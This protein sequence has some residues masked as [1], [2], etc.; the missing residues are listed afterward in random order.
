MPFGP[1]PPNVATAL[2][3]DR[4]WMLSPERLGE[5]FSAGRLGMAFGAFG[6]MV[7][8][9]FILDWMPRLMVDAEYTDAGAAT[10]V[11]QPFPAESQ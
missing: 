8:H 5:L 9:Y 11:G 6:F 10:V 1:S 7:S 2:L 3:T 4:E